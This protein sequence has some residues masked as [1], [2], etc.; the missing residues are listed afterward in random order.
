MIVHVD[1]KIGF[2]TT[3]NRQSTSD[4]IDVD[5]NQEFENEYPFRIHGRRVFIWVICREED[6]S[7]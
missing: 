4:K 7:F 5:I 6:L 1:L 3:V 2:T